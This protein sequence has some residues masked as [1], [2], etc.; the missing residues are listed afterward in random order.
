MCLRVWA[1]IIGVAVL[2]LVG[3]PPNVFAGAQGELPRRPLLGVA[4][5]P[6]PEDV[7][8][9]GNLAADEGVSVLD[10]VPG[11][12]A[13]AGGLRRG[14]VLLSINGQ[15]VGTPAQV[16]QAVAR[17]K[18]GDELSLEILRERNRTTVKLP[19]KERPREQDPA[20]DVLY[21]HVTSRGAR[22]RTV[23]TRPKR[24]GK[25][26][27]LLLIQGL[28]CFSVDNPPPGDPYRRI[29]YD[30]ARNGWVTMRVDKPGTGDS[31]GGP[32]PDTDF[33]TS[34]DGFRQALKALKADPAVDA[35]NVF[36]FGHSMG[37][38]MGPILAGETPVKGLAVYGTVLKSWYEYTLENLRRQL[39]LAGADFADVDRRVRL[40]AR[41]LHH[42]YAEGKSLADVAALGPEHR[43]WV[44]ES[45]QQGRYLFGVHYT[46]FQQLAGKNLA[47]YWQRVD[48]GVLS[49]WG[50]G[51]FVSTQE[52]HAWIAEIVNRARPGRAVH[53][54]LDLDHGFNRA[55]SQGAGFQRR[56]QPADFD[57]IIITT[58]REWANGVKGS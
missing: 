57:P 41:A 2:A 13:E 21:G 7:R 12:S 19:L 50:R 24:A 43:A 56:G 23:V 58:I 8:R 31:E 48:A 32:C 28:G 22:L 52:D 37:G 1:V 38:V 29:L 25:H 26:P 53:R 46:F 35:D 30:F 44:E 16:G 51:D 11:S 14:D 9:A 17:A 54:V 36:I 40:E 27:A 6:V 4:M 3:A 5:G 20:F 42:L 45:A 47:D 15:R 33:E 49:L 10:V 39:Q 55:A 34:L 18:T